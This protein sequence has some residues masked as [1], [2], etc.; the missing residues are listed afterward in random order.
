MAVQN[1]GVL[2][3]S[4]L[5][6]VM[7]LGYNEE[8]TILD[9]VVNMG[10]TEDEFVEWTGVAYPGGAEEKSK[11]EDMVYKDVRVETPKRIFVRTLALG[12]RVYM[13][14]MEDDKYDVLSRLSDAVGRAHKVS[15]EMARANL[16]NGAFLTA[17]RTGYDGKALCAT[18]HP[19]QNQ[20]ALATA[21]TNTTLASRTVSTWSNA[22]GTP[23]DLSYSTLTLGI[24]ALRRTVTREGEFTTIKPSILL[25]A[26]EYEAVAYEI[27]KSSDR[28]DTA[29]RAISGLTRW[30][31]KVVT[32]PYLT[33]TESWFLLADKH[34][35]QF[36]RRKP[37]T[38]K[39]RDA[40]GSWDALIE[41]VQRYAT[42]FHDPRGVWGNVSS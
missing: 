21:V 42:G 12:V 39:Q 27:T 33:A 14:D 41:S 9:K 6:K 5:K 36:F 22:A 11:G 18:D 1:V 4:G 3:Q 23:A 8:V 32:T 20:Y 17:Y 16:F 28:P 30:G 25:V 24:A 40:Q 31:L 37:L 38:I 2:F 34:D 19:L 29:S 13:E 10:T 7:A 26:P 35:L 15:E